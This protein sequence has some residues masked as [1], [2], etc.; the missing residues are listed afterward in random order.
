MGDERRFWRDGAVRVSR[1]GNFWIPGERV[2]V[3]SK[4][5]QHGQ[6]YVAWEAPD[7]VTDKD[8]IV[9]VHGGAIQGTEWLDTPDGRPGW[10]Q[11]LVEAGYPVFLTD[12]PTQGRSPFHPDVDGAMGP[13]F[14]YDDGRT[15][16]FPP[17]WDDTHTQWP[18]D[19]TDDAALDAFIAP[20]GPLPADLAE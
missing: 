18:F 13:A 15:V 4:T 3:D 6:M 1:R 17:D 19:V 5:Y 14:D 11:R 7:T 9:L 20:F 8:P 12:R 10:A 2:R 16:F